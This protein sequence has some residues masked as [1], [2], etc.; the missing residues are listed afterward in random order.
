MLIAHDDRLAA[1]VEDK[2]PCLSGPFQTARMAV[3][4]VP[5]ESQRPTIHQPARAPGSHGPPE[6]LKSPLD[7]STPFGHYF[8]P[9]AL[10][11]TAGNH[12]HQHRRSFRP[13]LLL[14]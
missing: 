8:E 14:Q 11:Q 3:V 4:I 6:E 12:R 7:Y 5:A 2:H 1:L 9:L 13:R 10:P